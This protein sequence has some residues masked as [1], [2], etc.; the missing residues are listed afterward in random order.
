MAQGL[1]V[2]VPCDLFP[3]KERW[4]R[5][6]SVR[7]HSARAHRGH[8]AARLDH[9]FL[10]KQPWQNVAQGREDVA[11]GREDSGHNCVLSERKDNQLGKKD[12]KTE[13]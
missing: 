7:L 5:C 6:P 1:P 4:S 10:E 13:F 12:L 2:G 11:Q 3:T 9:E 8:Q